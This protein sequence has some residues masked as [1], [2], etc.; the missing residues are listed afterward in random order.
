[1]I[2]FLEIQGPNC[3]E[4]LHHPLPKV[5]LVC[6]K[7]SRKNP[8]EKAHLHQSTKSFPFPLWKQYSTDCSWPVCDEFRLIWECETSDKDTTNLDSSGSVVPNSGFL[9]FME[10]P[11]LAP[12][13]ATRADCPKR[14]H[15]LD[16]K[17]ITLRLGPPTKFSITTHIV[18]STL[19]VLH[20]VAVTRIGTLWFN[21]FR[22]MGG[23]IL[24]SCGLSLCVEVFGLA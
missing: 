3:R 5:T 19:L 17:T 6:K 15:K 21:A 10:R 22:D 1:M 9:R 23:S 7:K 13:A 2:R 4:T 8:K 18:K 11:F 20:R 12:A 14:P 24:P 16:V